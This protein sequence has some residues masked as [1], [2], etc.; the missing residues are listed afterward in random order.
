M[1]MSV[2]V[3]LVFFLQILYVFDNSLFILVY[4]Y[5]WA[6]H[7]VDLHSKADTEVKCFFFSNSFSLKQMA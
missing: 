4:V 6:E 3:C 5:I 2:C 7:I 1:Y